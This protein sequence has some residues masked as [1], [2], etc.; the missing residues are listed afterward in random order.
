[1]FSKSCL[2]NST[3]FILF[4]SAKDFA[5]LIELEKEMDAAFESRR[6]DYKYDLGA[7]NKICYNLYLPLLGVI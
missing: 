7:A 3:F 1:M 2:T 6:I 4:C 5:Q